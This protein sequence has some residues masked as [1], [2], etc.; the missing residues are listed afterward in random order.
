M[1]QLFET[2][3]RKWKEASKEKRHESIEEMGRLAKEWEKLM[4]EV[5]KHFSHT[6]PVKNPPP[7]E[8][9]AAFSKIYPQLPVI[10]QEGK[11]QIID[12]EDRV[13]E[14][15]QAETTIKMYPHSKGQKKNPTT[16]YKKRINEPED[17]T[18]RL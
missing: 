3:G 9:K 5:N 2:E 16:R 17:E 12:N 6:D 10:S 11:Y 15:G 18:W 4:A 8:K 7:Y 13:I 14:M 1:L